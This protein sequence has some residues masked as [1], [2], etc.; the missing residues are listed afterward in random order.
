MTAVRHTTQQCWWDK[1]STYAVLFL[2]VNSMR[3]LIFKHP[4][5]HFWKERSIFLIKQRDLVI[6]HLYANEE[7]ETI[8]NIF[9]YQLIDSTLVQH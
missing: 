1:I 8:L 6:L 3:D 9:H 4:K 5:K 7:I 2:I